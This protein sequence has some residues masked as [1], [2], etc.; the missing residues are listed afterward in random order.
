VPGCS[1]TPPD[2]MP[3]Y[4]NDKDYCTIP[5]LPLPGYLAY[6]YDN[7][8]DRLFSHY[9]KTPPLGECEGDCD[10]D[11]DCIGDLKCFHRSRTE[12]VPGCLSG[13]STFGQDTSRRDY[14]YRGATSSPTLSTSPTQLSNSTCAPTPAVSP[15]P[16]GP[17]TYIPGQNT[18]VEADLSLSTG[19]RAEV[20]AVSGQRVALSSGQ[21]SAEPF[22]GKPD[23]AAVF[24]D[25]CGGGWTYVSNSEKGDSS[26]Y[27]GGVG[28]LYFN[29]R[30]EVIGYKMIQKKTR[31]NC[32]GGRTWWAT[33]LTCEEVS[34]GGVYEVEPK[35][36]NPSI[37]RKTLLG[38]NGRNGG[39]Y[40]G[41]AY[42]NRFPDDVN[43]RPKF[44]LT[45]DAPKGPLERFQPSLQA[46]A[47]AK[48]SGDY[49]NLL[50]IDPDGTAQTDYLVITPDTGIN[51]QGTFIWTASLRDGR[52]NARAYFRNCEG[53]DVRNGMLYMTCKVDKL[54]FIL[55]LDAMTYTQSS[56]IKGAFNDQPDQI[57]SITGVNGDILYFCEDGIKGGESGRSG[58]GV[59]ARDATG[60]GYTILQDESEK[61]KGE[62]TG[63]AFSPDRKLMIVAYQHEGRIYKIWR[64]DGRPFGGQMLDIRYHFD[65]TFAT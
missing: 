12:A 28:A 20:I 60:Q 57:A 2:P 40:E 61:I 37:K 31:R 21:V 62:T 15:S 44:F 32:S 52:R 16:T 7:T 54:L 36:N 47:D 63:L 1:G 35:N 58:S 4:D 8:G 50:H 17:A 41:V 27:T 13:D 6:V 5:P 10:N 65:D 22:H 49:S 34:G 53:I 25:E 30:N 29:A 33:W 59:H 51:T 3:G 42:D 24:V 55:D 48:A 14:C 46:L 56:T 11:D 39:A 38:Q 18:L 9:N 26:K 23:G 43:F 19:L 64:E 45:E